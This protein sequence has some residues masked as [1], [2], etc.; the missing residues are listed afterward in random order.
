MLP[1]SVHT[2][3]S[4]LP[5]PPTTPH[6]YLG[7]ELGQGVGNGDGSGGEL[8]ELKHTHGPVPDLK[9]GQDDVQDVI[10]P[11][12]RSLVRCICAVGHAGWSSAPGEHVQGDYAG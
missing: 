2:L 9:A 7:C 6:T 5:P 1:H 3:P 11:V 12:S 8:G 4:R 10:L